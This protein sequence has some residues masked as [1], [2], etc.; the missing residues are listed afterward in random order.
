M[1]EEG[2]EP[3]TGSRGI[4][5]CPMCELNCRKNE[6]PMLKEAER[7][8]HPS[9]C[10]YEQVMKDMK[11]ISKGGLWLGTI[12]YIERAKLDIAEGRKEALA[13]GSILA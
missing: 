9:Y 8:E 10:T 3:M 12:S 2:K 13:S 1:E 4:R 6:W 5:I 7:V 11:S